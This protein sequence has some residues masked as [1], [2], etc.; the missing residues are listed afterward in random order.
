MPVLI[1]QAPDASSA[2]SSVA[3]CANGARTHQSKK[4]PGR[5]RAFSFFVSQFALR[6]P[7]QTFY[8]P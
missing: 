2:A 4:G 5:S 8:L 7:V 1:Q 6:K 3:C